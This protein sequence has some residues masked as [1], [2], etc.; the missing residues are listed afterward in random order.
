MGMSRINKNDF[1][2]DTHILI[3]PHIGPYSEEKEILAWIDELKTMP[4]RPEVKDSI[5]ETEALLSRRNNYQ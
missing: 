1:D 5:A 3:D 2:S 4:D